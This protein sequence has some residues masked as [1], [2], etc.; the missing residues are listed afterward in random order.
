MKVK[1]CG[2]T[3]Q[4]DAS[5]AVELGVDAL[6]FI[7]AKSPRQIEPDTA[8][9][10]INSLPPFV[11]SVGVFVNEDPAKIR[12]IVAF[13]GLDII[14]FHGDEPPDVCSGFMPRAIKAFQLK[15]ESSLEQIKPY[16]G[17]VRAFL[18]DT[19]SNEKRGGTGK[20]FDWSLAIKGKAQGV[21]M[22]LSGGLSPSNIDDAVSTVR[23][24]AVD[25]NSG[26]EKSPGIKDHNLME[27]LM[28]VITQIP[29]TGGA[30][31]D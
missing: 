14:Q 24:Y 5:A 25:V 10:I 8:R 4:Q 7:F 2:I 28:K 17:K 13:C 11:M 1:I 19:Y 18:F 21:P 12:E 3:N 30:T 6:G 20:A 29:N 22:I 16:Y 31:V 15:D 26:V 23:P 9:A 27:Q